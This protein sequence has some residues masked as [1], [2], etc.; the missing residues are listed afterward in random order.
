MYESVCIAPYK[1]GA[2]AQVSLRVAYRRRSAHS[3]CLMQPNLPADADL[4]D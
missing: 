1:S 2:K 4:A 3:P